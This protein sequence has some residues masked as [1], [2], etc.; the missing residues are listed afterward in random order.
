ML[1]ETL[2]LV[3]SMPDPPPV[4]FIGPPGSA[5]TAR[6]G[7]ACAAVNMPLETVIASLRDPTDF[8]GLPILNGNGVHLAPPSWATRL[9]S[10]GGVLF[11]DEI[12]TA[13][14]AT[15]AALL[16]VILD[17]VVGDLTLPR[18]VRIL[19]AM[20]PPEESAGGF[21]LSPPLAN[22][23][24]HFPVPYPSFDSWQAFESG[25]LKPFILPDM[26]PFDYHLGLARAES[27]GFLH[28]NPSLM[29]ESPSVLSGRTV[30]AFA[31]P[32]TWTMRNKLAAA[33]RVAYGARSPLALSA[34]FIGEPAAIELHT[35]L[36][37]SDLP[38]PEAL[39]ADP[40]KLPSDMRADRLYC[41]LLA[42]AACATSATPPQSANL[43]TAKLSDLRSRRWASGWAVMKRAAKGAEDLTIM[44]AKRMMVGAPPITQLPQDCI[45]VVQSCRPILEA[46][47]IALS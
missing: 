33:W 8:G 9:A 23:F 11:L 32:R 37:E 39:L 21:D 24:G 6:I 12:N 43:D 27:H 10:S 30:P 18:S 34:A 13:S 2:P 28:R 26:A 41:T 15:Q 22:R 17:R 42:V 20:N 25:T 7:Q 19:A 29:A 47:G 38:D 44:A 40:K 14:P 35:W 31:T 36:D 16:R 45:Q 3:L 5:K 4:L 1:D 46:A